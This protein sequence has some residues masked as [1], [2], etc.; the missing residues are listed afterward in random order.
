M[1]KAWERHTQAFPSPCTPDD[2]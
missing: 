1:K 2:R